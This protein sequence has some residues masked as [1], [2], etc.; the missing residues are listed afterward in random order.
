MQWEKN[1][2]WPRNRTY[3][4]L[5]FTLSLGCTVSWWLTWS[6]DK[7]ERRGEMKEKQKLLMKAKWR[8]SRRERERRK[9]NEKQGD[10]KKQHQEEERQRERV[11][12]CWIHKRGKK[13]KKKKKKK[14]RLREERRKNS[15]TSK[16]TV[17]QMNGTQHPLVCAL[18][19]YVCMC[20]C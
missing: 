10:Q 18:S 6:K 4:S 19:M 3:H 11:N 2:E 5:H 14:V 13:E 1:E 17:E 9:E 7:V 8:V 20:M 15:C 16:D 12:L